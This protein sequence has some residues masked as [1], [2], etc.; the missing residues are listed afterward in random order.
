MMEWW[1]DMRMLCARYLVA[2]EQIERTGPVEHAVR[3]AGYDDASEEGSSIEE[4]EEQEVD[5][6][7]R[8]T[9]G[10]TRL[11][12]YEYDKR[13]SNVGSLVSRCPFTHFTP[14]LSFN[15]RKKVN[16]H[17]LCPRPHTHFSPQQLPVPFPTPY[18]TPSPLLLF[19]TRFLPKPL[20]HPTNHRPIHPKSS[21]LQD[22][23][24]MHWDSKQ[25]T[26]TTLY[27]V[28]NTPAQAPFQSTYQILLVLV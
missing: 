14:D 8:E 28:L 15:L 3:S 7:Y 20:A 23:F 17:M 22:T 26:L 10:A 11:S 27:L 13:Y 21:N 5:E 25:D 16:L 19:K 6:S 12:A 1:N 24:Q 9:A 2:S 18:T 4:E